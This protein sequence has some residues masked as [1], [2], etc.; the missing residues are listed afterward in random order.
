MNELQVWQAKAEDYEKR[1]GDA[2]QHCSVLRD[3]IESLRA[4]N[5]RLKMGKEKIRDIVWSMYSQGPEAIDLAL[6]ELELA[7]KETTK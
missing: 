3:E 5:A 4:E 1:W 7:T 2:A 6:N